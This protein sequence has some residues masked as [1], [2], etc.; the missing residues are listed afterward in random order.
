LK[1]MDE[2]EIRKLCNQI[3][4]SRIKEISIKLQEGISTK[5]SEEKKCPYCGEKIE[6]TY[7]WLPI[8][9]EE[10]SERGLINAIIK[11]TEFARAHPLV[12]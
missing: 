11:R 5:V 8:S 2:E 12:L 10:F 9:C 1:K 7:N 6:I 4:D 3:I